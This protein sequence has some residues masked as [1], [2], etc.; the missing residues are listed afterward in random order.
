MLFKV[1][2]R[3]TWDRGLPTSPMFC[4]QVLLLEELVETP[5]GIYDT[6]QDEV[7][8]DPEALRVFLRAV[9][10]YGSKRLLVAEGDGAGSGSGGII[11]KLSRQR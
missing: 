3:E 11:P 9:F 8:V 1:G 2:S 7:Q 10:T 5:S 6:G 4:G